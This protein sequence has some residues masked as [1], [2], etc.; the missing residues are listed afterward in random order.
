MVRL[1]N[2]AEIIRYKK[3]PVHQRRRG[4]HLLQS[5][6][7]GLTA[8][9]CGLI[10]S[11]CLDELLGRNLAI[12]RG[13][14]LKQ[15]EDLLDA[16]FCAYLAWHFWRWGEEGNEVYGDLRTGYVVVPKPSRRR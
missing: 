2:L 1:F 16:V 7:R 12:R 10:P 14:M 15:H 13:N 11:E 6:L 9:D 4:M 8:R 5:H 3:G